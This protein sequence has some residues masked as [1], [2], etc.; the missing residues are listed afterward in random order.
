MRW[1]TYWS[2]LKQQL[3]CR[4]NVSPSQTSRYCS[5]FSSL[6][7]RSGIIPSRGSGR[8]ACGFS[9]WRPP[10]AVVCGRGAMAR[11]A[12]GGAT[13]GAVVSGA[14]GSAAPL[15]VCAQSGDASPAVTMPIAEA[16]ACTCH[17]VIMSIF[18]HA[19]RAGPDRPKS[20][21]PRTTAEKA[22]RMKEFSRGW[23]A[24]TGSNRRPTRCKRAALP[25]E[26]TAL[27]VS[28]GHLPRPRK[29][30]CLGPSLWMNSRIPRL[31]SR[32]GQ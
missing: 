12:G 25:A 24:V 21:A 13:R 31:P 5:L 28:Y 22:A 23:W 18:P 19:R 27:P 26:L 17:R 16:T 11:L 3:R 14:D 6:G 15:G 4:R 20:L 7:G 29:T 9:G 10:G 2:C 8:I 1:P 32:A 30:Y